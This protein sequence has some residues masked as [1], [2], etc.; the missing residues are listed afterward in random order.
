MRT[1][2]PDTNTPAVWTRHPW[3]WLPNPTLLL[4][5]ARAEAGRQ[6]EALPFIPRCSQRPPMVAVPGHGRRSPQP[7]VSEGLGASHIGSLAA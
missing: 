6:H 7:V 4:R 1:H 2:S 5:S 3:T